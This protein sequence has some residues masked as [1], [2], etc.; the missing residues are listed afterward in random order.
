MEIK[1]WKLEKNQ[2]EIKNIY[3]KH[4]DENSTLINNLQKNSIFMLRRWIKEE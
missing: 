4:E 2:N 3:E 1:Y